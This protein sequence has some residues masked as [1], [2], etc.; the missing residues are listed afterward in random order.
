MRSQNHGLLIFMSVVL[1]SITIFHKPSAATDLSDAVLDGFLASGGWSEQ[2]EDVISGEKLD[3]MFAKALVENYENDMSNIDAVKPLGL[4]VLAG[5]VAGWGIDWEAGEARD[6]ANKSWSGPS[7][8]NSGKHLMSYAKGGVG[9]PHADSGFLQDLIDYLKD[10]HP[11]LA[12]EGDRFFQL[13]GINF[14]VLY[15]NGGH[16]NKPVTVIY[17]DLDGNQFGHN[18]FGYAGDRYC[19]TYKP[20]ASTDEKDWQ[21]FRH[22]IRE[23]LRKRDVQKWIIE[24]WLAKYWLP[25]YEKVVVDNGGKI[26]EA[27]INARIRN[28]SPV[29]ANCAIKHAKNVAD[30][31]GAQLEAYTQKKCRGKESHS[32][33]FG[34]MKR[35]VVIFE[36]FS[37]QQ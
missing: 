7:S 14:D 36:T 27:F 28:S 33:R 12:S 2:A 30:P 3:P 10:N 16:C 19:N 4:L 35:P 11:N 24:R 5:A 32:R 37:K 23:A 15:A 22:W 34:V 31:I 29:T 13:K 18:R 1:V 9:I 20:R 6:P 26:T 17:T 25:S 21:I 8:V